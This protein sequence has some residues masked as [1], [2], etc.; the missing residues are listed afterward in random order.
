MAIAAF[1]VVRCLRLNEKGKLENG[2]WGS[3]ASARGYE[4]A[5]VMAEILGFP[6][7]D[8]FLVRPQR[9]DSSLRSER[10]CFFLSR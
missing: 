3:V 4:S 9:A 5:V 8:W 7:D 1:M 2:N 6:Q 10:Q